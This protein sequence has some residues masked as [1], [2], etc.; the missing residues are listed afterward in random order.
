MME[1]NVTLFICENSLDEMREMMV[2][3]TKTCDEI[4]EDFNNRYKTS[5]IKECFVELM[6]KVNDRRLLNT[7]L[8]IFLEHVATT[9]TVPPTT[10]VALGNRHGIRQSVSVPL[11][12]FQ[13]GL[14]I[15]C[16]IISSEKELVMFKCIEPYGTL[17]RNCIV[18]K[19]KNKVAI[20]PQED[21][22]LEAH[23]YLTP[24]EIYRLPYSEYSTSEQYSR[25]R[26][27]LQ[28]LI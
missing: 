13:H 20:V 6:N 18:A 15:D 22:Y 26:S 8:N 10:A 14:I 25:G 11:N 17:K 24:L 4:Y 2:K 23:W 7:C 19:I 28:Y 1:S 27:K 3:E 9:S 21:L 16:C 5:M 12:T